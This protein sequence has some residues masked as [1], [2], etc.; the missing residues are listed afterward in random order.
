M[1]APIVYRPYASELDL[2]P[3][4]SLIA[5]ALSEP[6]S[7]YT[8]RYFL[9]QWPQLCFLALDGD[10]IVGCVINRIEPHRGMMRGYIA[11]LVVS[12]KYRGRKIGSTLVKMTVNA[13]KEGGADEVVLETEVS[14]RTACALY[15]HLGFIR[16]KR[17]A[18]YYLN[19]GDAFRLKLI[20]HS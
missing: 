13:M 15:E 16:D 14:N 4:A 17:L 9:H 6:Y 7:I 18:R 1:D 2:P 5:E 8:Y 12:E 11:M 10:T 19:G 3:M 20:V